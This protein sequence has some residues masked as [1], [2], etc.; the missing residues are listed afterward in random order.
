MWAS[1][2]AVPA[3]LAF[4]L[5]VLLSILLILRARARGEGGGGPL[6]PEMQ[7]PGRGGEEDGDGGLVGELALRKIVNARAS[8]I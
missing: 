2:V 4:L 1:R 8:P 7:F 6:G 5:G 3:L